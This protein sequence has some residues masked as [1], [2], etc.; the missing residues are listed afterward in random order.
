VP[1]KAKESPVY[2]APVIVSDY[3]PITEQEALAVLL[4]EPLIVIEVTDGQIVLKSK[5]A[6][7][8]VEY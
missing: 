5:D 2:L 3:E 1:Y 6:Q 7:M 4:D 8:T